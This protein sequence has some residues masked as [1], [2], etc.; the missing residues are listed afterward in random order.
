MPRGVATRGPASADQDL[1]LAAELTAARF[2][3]S[4][5]GCPSHALQPSSAFS[6]GRPKVSALWWSHP[7]GCHMTSFRAWRAVGLLL[8]GGVGAQADPCDTC[9]SCYDL[10]I[11]CCVPSCSITGVGDS[12]YGGCAGAEG[13]WCGTNPC[14][15]CSG[16]YKLAVDECDKTIS[17]Q[18]NCFLSGDMWCGAPEPTCTGCDS[19]YLPSQGKAGAFCDSSPTG[20]GASE[21]ECTKNNYIDGVSATWCPTLGGDVCA[22]CPY[23]Y[24]DGFC[25]IMATTLSECSSY[26]GYQ[27]CGSTPWPT[28]S[29]TP[30]SGGASSDCKDSTGQLCTTCL[31]P[32]GCDS[33]YDT[34]GDCNGFGR[35]CDPSDC[36][37]YT[38]V[39]CDGC[40][41]TSDLSCRRGNEYADSAA[42]TAGGFGYWC[43]TGG[44]CDSCNYCYHDWYCDSTIT[45]ETD[46]VVSWASGV[47]QWCGTGAA[48]CDSCNY[49]YHD[50]Y[51]DFSYTDPAFC[52]TGGLGWQWCGGDVCDSCNSCYRD[53]YCD[54]SIYSESACLPLSG[55]WCGWTT[56]RPT[57]APTPA[58]SDAVEGSFTCAGI[59]LADAEAHAYV[60]A[61]GIAEIYNVDPYKVIVTFAAYRRRLQSSGDVVVSYVVLYAS[62][63]AATAAATAAS[64]HTASTYQSAVQSA[65]S[66]RGITLF[67][68]AGRHRGGHAVSI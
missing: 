24:R 50:G 40:L 8:A 28:R 29:P 63:A 4:R 65:A 59:T 42:C 26:A 10:N 55:S 6:P 18:H 62:A 36:L 7:T 38:G 53:G 2:W 11:G 12:L 54:T 47:G 46:C 5:K 32:S 67:A 15:S 3:T 60:Y 37:D 17:D 45:T 49:C 43:G 56:P 41:V 27:W 16:C 61:E 52:T 9:S 21:I 44:E 13:M 35:W 33:T 20:G 31:T 68:L 23:C 34:H 22:N 14:D 30:S 1:S 19:C 58:T 66:G 64:S 57:P 48:V 25:D 39:S 51:C